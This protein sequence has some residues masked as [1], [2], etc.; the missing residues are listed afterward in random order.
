MQVDIVTTV[1]DE[2]QEQGIVL[3]K[4]DASEICESMIQ[5]M[6]TGIPIGAQTM[7]TFD[8]VL[9]EC[10]EILHKKRISLE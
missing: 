8:Y 4:R 5:V 7:D 9:R 6:K 1:E 2:L 3:K 10:K